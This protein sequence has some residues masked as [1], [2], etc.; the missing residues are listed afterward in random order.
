VLRVL[1]V[2]D[3]DVLFRRTLDALREVGRTLPPPRNV[4][5]Y[6]QPKTAIVLKLSNLQSSWIWKIAAATDDVAQG[7]LGGDVI[8]D[9]S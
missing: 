5:F 7:A 3:E 2:A 1:V 8:D 6:V 9:A 4:E